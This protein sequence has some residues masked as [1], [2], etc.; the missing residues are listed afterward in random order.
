MNKR[1][2]KNVAVLFDTGLIYSDFGVAL[3][4]V[5]LLPSPLFKTDELFIMSTLLWYTRIK[6]TV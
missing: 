4:T 2:K 3:S 1:G 6:E 5:F